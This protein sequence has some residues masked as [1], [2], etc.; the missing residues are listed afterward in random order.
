MTTKTISIERDAYELLA[1]EKRARESISQVVRR[2]VSAPPAMHNPR[3]AKALDRLAAE[4]DAAG[5]YDS[6]YTGAEDE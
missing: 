4:V 1:G 3:R 5:L 6:T 2:L